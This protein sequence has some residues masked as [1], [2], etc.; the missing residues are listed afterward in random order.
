VI[1]VGNGHG[2][3]RGCDPQRRSTISGRLKAATSVVRRA[4][5]NGSFLARRRPR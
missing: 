1:R 4:G 5:M 2:E 3:S